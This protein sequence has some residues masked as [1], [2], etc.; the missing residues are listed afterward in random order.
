MNRMAVVSLLNFQLKITDGTFRSFDTG[1]SSSTITTLTQLFGADILV[2]DST[3][4]RPVS[5]QGVDLAQQVFF[6]SDQPVTLKLVV[7]GSTLLLTSGFV[8][9]PRVPSVIS[10]QNIVEIYVSNASGSQAR[11]IVQGAGVA[12]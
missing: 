1:Q 9:M 10:V 11:L 5:L 3:V 2:D 8:L 6:Y 12:A 7:N 4:D